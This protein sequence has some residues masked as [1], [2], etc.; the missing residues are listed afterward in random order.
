[1][2]TVQHTLY[3]PAAGAPAVHSALPFTSMASTRIAMEHM[4]MYYWSWRRE[5]NQFYYDYNKTMA[6]MADSTV[7]PGDNED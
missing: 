1:M 6:E 5:H 3:V 2:R 4:Q 7:S